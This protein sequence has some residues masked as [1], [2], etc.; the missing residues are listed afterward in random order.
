LLANS[1]SSKQEHPLQLDSIPE[2][3]IAYL[4]TREGESMQTSFLSSVCV[5]SP[6]LREKVM[7]AEL[8]TRQEAAIYLGVSV[9]TL[10]RWASQREKVRYHR[11]GK[12]ALYRRADL[13]AY[14]NASA[15]EPMRNSPTCGKAFL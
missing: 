2:R 6:H 11:V 4:D 15:I 8:L 9:S 12:R 10:A 5:F 7:K 13:D 14:V 3:Y 1:L